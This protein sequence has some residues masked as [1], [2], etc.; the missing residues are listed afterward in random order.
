VTLLLSRGAVLHVLLLDADG[1]PVSGRIINFSR[2]GTFSSIAEDSDGEGRATFGNLAAGDYSLF[3]VLGGGATAS[4]HVRLAE[5]EVADVVLGGDQ[6][7]A[8]VEGHVTRAGEPVA[9]L[10]LGLHGADAAFPAGAST[11]EGGFYRF[12]K[13]PAG[14][15]DLEVQGDSGPLGGGD[16]LEVPRG[17]GSVRHDV[18]L[19]GNV[20]RVRVREE[21]SGRALSSIPILLRSTESGWADWFEQTDAHGEGRF[22][23]LPP[24]SYLLAAGP[25]A[26]P[27]F[28]P[29][30]R[31][32][33]RVVG[34]IVFA[35]GTSET[36]EIEVRLGAPARLRVKVLDA[37]GRPVT[38]ARVFYLDP[39][40]RPLSGYSMKTTDAQGLL[41]IDSLPPGPGSILARKEGAGQAETPV[42]L[43]GGRI[44]E[45]TLTLQPGTLVFA[46][47]V[48]RGK[49]VL[50]GV[51]IFMFDARGTPVSHLFGVSEADRN[52]KAF[53][54]GREQVFGPL[55][56]G[57][58]K[59]VL[60]RPGEAGRRLA[61]E[62]LPGDPEVH[63]MLEYR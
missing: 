41:E 26:L 1:A 3:V 32:A 47:V 14:F 9:G 38:G 8:T 10:T 18:R 16:G 29:S 37:A 6:D 24:G 55:A 35:D 53:L 40:G 44:G 4:G 46:R 60:T 27:A 23:D 48:R 56:P 22:L 50:Q 54:A 57:R 63:W 13:V 25:A 31:A 43:E 45:A 62:I 59:V 2:D 33:S 5:D 34:P 7:L 51:S 36:R 20:L 15:Y 19:S 12:E 61:K 28:A 21:D 49:G 11:D 39:R 17:G 30:S 52:N 42:R 58:Y